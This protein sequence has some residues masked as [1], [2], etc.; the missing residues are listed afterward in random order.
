MN[1]SIEMKYSEG[2]KVVELK[3][4]GPFRGK[5]KGPIKS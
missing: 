1:N 2:D 4:S 5:L 3:L